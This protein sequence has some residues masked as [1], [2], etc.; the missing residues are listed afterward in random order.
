MIHMC[1]FKDTAPHERL[2][3]EEIYNA[4]SLF[5]SP[6]PPP[7]PLCR[8]MTSYKDTHEL[9]LINEQDEW[10]GTLGR[11]VDQPGRSDARMSSL[12]FCSW[13]T[14]GSTNHLL[15]EGKWGDIDFGDIRRLKRE[16][17]GQWG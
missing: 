5:E 9:T 13:S 15:S 4:P 8:V 10:T 12:G 7:P 17:G 2:K 6:P 14:L 3:V 1:I 11:K 16:E